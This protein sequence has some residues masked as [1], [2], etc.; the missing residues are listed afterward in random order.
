[1][2]VYRPTDRDRAMRRVASW[3]SGGVAGGV[4]LT[5]ALTA[6]SAAAFAAAT[7]PRTAGSVPSIP[8]E[9]APVQ[10]A[11][12]APVVIIQV[13]HVPASSHGLPAS[14][15]GVSPPRRPPAGSSAP[16][17]PDTA[18][19]FRRLVKGSIRTERD[20]TVAV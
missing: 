9:S 6:V 8:L 17:P 20:T 10:S 15:R 18:A 16:P 13:V 3:T 4:V 5:G 7:P 12:P 1:M 14:S 2:P 19:Q 11:R